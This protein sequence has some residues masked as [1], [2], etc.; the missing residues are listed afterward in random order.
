MSQVISE[1]ST[2]TPTVS[3]PSAGD[4]LNAAV[5]RGFLGALANRTRFLFDRMPELT[6]DL[7]GTPATP[8]LA[9]SATWTQLSG[10]AATIINS[11]A[12][13]TYL[14]LARANFVFT[15][16]DGFLDFKLVANHT[17][18]GPSD[19]PGSQLK[20]VFLPG[21]HR[22]IVSLGVFTLPKGGTWNF[23]AY[24]QKGLSV[25]DADWWGE[26]TILAV[27]L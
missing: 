17:I 5:M 1:V 21:W 9:I 14:V 22:S 15:V 20:E 12:G 6:A 13:E 26:S 10:L 27:R 24:A 19:I 2:F 18:D 25:G 3:G 16:D 11:V 4:G 7:G 23:R 8:N